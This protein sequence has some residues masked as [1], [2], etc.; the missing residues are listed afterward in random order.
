MVESLLK[1]QT[2]ESDEANGS[3]QQSQTKV[4]SLDELNEDLIQLAREAQSRKA[5]EKADAPEP[6]AFP[7]FGAQVRN[8]G[9]WLL[10]SD[11]I[12]L[13][14]AFLIGGLI[15]RLVRSVVYAEP[16]SQFWNFETLSQF[17]TYVVFGL[18]SILWLDTKGH[19]RQRLPYWESIGHFATI[20]MIG[21]LAC[22]FIAFAAKGDTSRLWMSLNWIL[23]GIMVLIGRN[24]VRKTLAARKQWVIPSLIIGTGPSAQHLARAI[25]REKSMGYEICDNIPA[26]KLRELNTPQAWKSLL[27]QRGASHV[28]LA[29]EGSEIE[30]HPF[31]LKAMTSARV[32]CSIVPP[33]LGLPSTTLSPHHFLMQDVLILHDTNR[34]KLP[35]ARVMKRTLDIVVSSSALIAL[36]PLMI[37]VA[38]IVRHDGSPAFFIQQRVGRHGKLFPCFKFRSMRS[39]AEEYLQKYL[40]TNPEAAEEW[41]SFQKLKN[42]VRVTRFGNFIRKTSIDELPQLFN[43]LIGDM[44]LVGPRPIMP[45]QNEIYAEDIDFYHSV[46]PGITGPWQVSGRN[47]LTFKERVELESWYARNWSVWLDIVIL[48]KTVPTL[49]F[50]R[51]QTS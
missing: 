12:A 34:L 20:A 28:F 14:S 1:T 2:L 44:S 29:L 43:V 42:D 7:D 45:E 10:A 35:M 5:Q 33:W 47:T 21:L 32:P 8:C 27:R 48:M 39:D 51:E 15:S 18:V 41:H 37:I 17:V 49:L 24:T 25:R 3:A 38:L 16:F 36:S 30:R 22:G 46:R 31:E 9:R 23:F 50:K 6:I 40:A 19:Y 11:L 26:I 13:V 4:R